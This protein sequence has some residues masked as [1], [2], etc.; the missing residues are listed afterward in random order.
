M[1]EPARNSE[2]EADAADR[3]N[4]I[5]AVADADDPEV[6]DP[7]SMSLLIWVVLILNCFILGPM[8]FVSYKV[9]YTAY[10]TERAFFVSQVSLILNTE[11]FH[12]LP[13]FTCINIINFV[14]NYL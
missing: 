11:S 5:I 6:A 7:P 13:I 2:E 10:C 3:E 9:L 1:P 14:V 12:D 4:A 8:N